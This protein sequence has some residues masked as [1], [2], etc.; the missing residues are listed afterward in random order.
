MSTAVIAPLMV[1]SIAA[2]RSIISFTGSFYSFIHLPSSEEQLQEVGQPKSG[3]DYGRP[4]RQHSWS[5]V[6]AV[7]S[8]PLLADKL[9]VVVVFVNAVRQNVHVPGGGGLVVVCCERS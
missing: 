4:E 2:K 1:W 5:P 9:T 6:D 8:L 3:P 7:H